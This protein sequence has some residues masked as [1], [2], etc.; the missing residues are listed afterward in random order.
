MY[1]SPNEPDFKEQLN[2]YEKFE[3]EIAVLIHEISVEGHDINAPVTNINGWRDYW[4][5]TVD[6]DGDGVGDDAEDHVG[7]DP[8]DPDDTPTPE[9]L[10]EFELNLRTT[11]LFTALH[12]LQSAKIISLLIELGANVNVSEKQTGD[13]PLHLA[14]EYPT[15]RVAEVLIA[16]GANV[17][18]LNKEGETPLDI[19]I[20]HPGISGF[21]PSGSG[22]MPSGYNTTDT[23]EKTEE[24]QFVTLLRKHGA[25]TGDELIEEGQ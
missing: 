11:P 3:N 14:S 20:E 9:A 24:D 13:T 8:F 16:N 5:S 21:M 4:K 10:A 1:G 15:S 2:Q 6:E 19:R 23:H 22:F 18:A 17:N 7:T 25:K 12:G